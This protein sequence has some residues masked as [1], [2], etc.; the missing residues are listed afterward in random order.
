M[1]YD[2]G[3]E[4]DQ[5]LAWNLSHLYSVVDTLRAAVPL[6]TDEI[7]EAATQVGKS[8]DYY[9]EKAGE[10]ARSRGTTDETEALQ[11]VAIYTSMAEIVGPALD[12]MKNKIDDIRDIVGRINNSKWDFFYQQNGNVRSYKSNWETAKEYPWNPTAVLQ[13]TS[14]QNA[15]SGELK[16]A[17]ASLKDVDQ[18]TQAEVAL[19]VERVADSVKIELGNRNIPLDPKLAEILRTN[20]VNATDQPVQLYPDGALLDAIRLVNPEFEPTVV[21]AEE[22]EL[23]DDLVV[24]H[25]LLGL[26]KFN[27]IK[28][29]AQAAG[30]NSKWE[31]QNPDTE[32][33]G[34][35]DA[36]RHAYWNALLTQEF[37]AE[38]TEKFT[39][40]HERTGGNPVHR[41]AMD[42]YNNSIGRAIG[43]AN[44]DAS[45]EELKLEIENAIDR[46]ELVVIDGRDGQTPQIAWSNIAPERTTS[47]AGAEIPLPGVK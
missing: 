14:D 17:L 27:E 23:L 30:E 24:N 6:L 46:G 40:A 36:L 10:A 20:Q 38:W 4:V 28:Q 25:G 16:D 44:M 45:P 9:G 41:E 21:T 42:V 2:N 39:D 29:M 5:V 8:H 35:G 26:N 47:P 7:E 1:S 37:G 19:L 11:T 33:D 13:K 34:Q 3:L 31:G 32:A 12:S 43:L 22:K 15:L 18:L